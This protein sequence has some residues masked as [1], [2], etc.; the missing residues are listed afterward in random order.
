MNGARDRLRRRR[1][2][3]VFHLP[4]AVA[5][6]GPE[7]L[8]LLREEHRDVLAALRRTPGHA[9]ALRC[10]ASIGIGLEPGDG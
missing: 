10:R 7:A 6:A 1:V 4:D 8:A 3:R 5:P 2:R 9:I